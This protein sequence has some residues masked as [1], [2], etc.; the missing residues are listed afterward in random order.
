MSCRIITDP[1]LA[2][3]ALRRGKLVALPTETV[4][5]LGGDATNPH[6]VARIFAAKE[7]PLFDPLILHLASRAWLPRVVADV[8]PAAERLA[9]RFWPGPLTLVLPRKETVL[10]L[11]T[12]GLPTVA[13]RVPRHKKMQA[14]LEHLDRPIAAPS[15]NRFGRLSP[16]RPEHVI[17]Q[18]GEVI[19]YVLD[20]G[21]CRVGVEST[22]V[23]VDAENRVTLLRPGGLPVERIEAVV[24][25]IR[26]PRR[27]SRRRPLAPGQLPQHYAPLTPVKLVRRPP[28]SPPSGKRW[29]LLALQPQPC[30]GYAAYGILSTEGNLIT[31][32]ARF[33]D[34]LHQLDRLGLERI[35][36]VE[37]PEHGLGLAIN[38]RLRR[39]AAASDTSPVQVRRVETKPAHP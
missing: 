36:A 23:Q 11:V 25:P 18:L 12:A 14:V 34:V 39:A 1:L 31:A 19:D 28:L 8:P 29:G 16:T 5:G 4:Y 33:F 10:D 20:G 7:R 32:A 35:V 9:R 6:A 3:R 22:I 15:A 30:R 38:D 27:S 21:P 2:A 13:V 24:G 26:R 37:L 17:E